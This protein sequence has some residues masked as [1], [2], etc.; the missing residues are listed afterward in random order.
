MITDTSLTQKKEKICLNY[1]SLR[2]LYTLL[3]ELEED[4][5][6]YQTIRLLKHRLKQWEAIE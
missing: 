6:H 1:V 4:S 2:L 5:T 3:D